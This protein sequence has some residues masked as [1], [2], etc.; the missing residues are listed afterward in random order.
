MKKYIVY[1]TAVAALIFAVNVPAVRGDALAD[2]TESITGASDVRGNIFEVKWH[3]YTMN[4]AFA[5]DKPS[6]AGNDLEK[7]LGAGRKYIEVRFAFVSGPRGY[8]GFAVADLAVAKEQIVLMDTLNRTY[9]SRAITVSSN[10][11]VNNVIPLGTTLTASIE[12]LNVTQPAVFS[13]IYETPEALRIADLKMR[14]D[15]KSTEPKILMYARA[16]GNP[17]IGFS[18]KTDKKQHPAPEPEAGRSIVY[19]LRQSWDQNGDPTA[20]AMDGNWQ[21]SAIGRDYLYFSA[22]PGEHMFCSR[23][24][25]KSQSG[26][27]AHGISLFI[28]STTAHYVVFEATLKPDTAYFMETQFPKMVVAKRYSHKLVPVSEETGRDKIKKLSYRVNE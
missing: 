25:V 24:T 15:G 13:I 5:N 21:G 10:D 1:I 28:N 4:I 14:I 20:F 3:G 27:G 12:G 22:D 9:E 2:F 19:V 18:T 26:G 7:A 16:C 23:L 11:G 6:L 8:K 17:V